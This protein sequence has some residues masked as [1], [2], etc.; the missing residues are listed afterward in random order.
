MDE[1]VQI[2]WANLRDFDSHVPELQSILS[3]LEKARVGRFRFIRNRNNYIICHGLLR[4][5]LGDFTGQSPSRL[6][7]KTGRYGKPELRGNIEER[8]IHFNISHAQDVALYGITR[9]CP[10]GV[11]VERVRTFPCYER[12]AREFFTQAE[13]KSLKATSG[14]VRA[15][16]FFELWTRKEALLKARGEG[17]GDG[18]AERVDAL[19]EPGVWVLPHT[20][21]AS[22]DW[23]VRSFS[24][25]EGYI[26]SVA[27]G[28]ANVNF[29]CRG[30]PAAKFLEVKAESEHQQL[31]P[32]FHRARLCRAGRSWR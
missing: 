24:P 16:R 8:R 23:Q 32:C 29:V 18:L 12:V 30:V 15:Q 3:V 9:A 31:R 22:S 19:L 13:C 25:V 21:G 1:Q 6:C 11:D 27:F 7:L 28:Q 14:E 17:L 26:A 5:L 4:M 10:I 2:W 20:I